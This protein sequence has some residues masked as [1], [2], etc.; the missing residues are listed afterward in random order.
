[1]SYF[2]LPHLLFCLQI[3]SFSFFIVNQYNKNTALEYDFTYKMW[4][5]PSMKGLGS[6]NVKKKMEGGQFLG[7]LISV[8]FSCQIKSYMS[9]F[10]LLIWEHVRKQVRNENWYSLT[11]SDAFAHW[12]ESH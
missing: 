4:K 6:W 9:G 8:H 5:N 10:A 12:K 7:F 3:Q 1:M 11:L 2:H